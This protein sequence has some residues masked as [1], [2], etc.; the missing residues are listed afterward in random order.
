M[1]V[2]CHGK[3]PSRPSQIKLLCSGTLHCSALYEVEQ[4]ISISKADDSVSTTDLAL[5]KMLH[6]HPT[7][8]FRSTKEI[9]VQDLE[10]K[11]NSSHHMDKAIQIRPWVKQVNILFKIKKTQLYR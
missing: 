1:N 6:R 11:C 8:K 9:N 2:F 10:K 5:K 4:R 7:R 3:E